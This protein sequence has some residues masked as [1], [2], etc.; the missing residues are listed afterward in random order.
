MK[1]LVDV[2]VFIVIY[3]V[4]EHI[5]ALMEPRTWLSFNKIT[6]RRSFQSVVH[7]L[8]HE[9]E[10][11]VL[12]SRNLLG[13][14]WASTASAPPSRIPYL[15]VRP[16][17][18]S[19][20]NPIISTRGTLSH[21]RQVPAKCDNNLPLP[22]C[23]FPAEVQQ[24]DILPSYCKQ[25]SLSHLHGDLFCIFVKWDIPNF[26]HGM[27]KLFLCSDRLGDVAV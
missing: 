3:K 1:N 20:C 16:S 27:L 7:L 17:L 23:S 24:A 11:P 10:E 8:I 26:C 21:S 12:V 15:Q 5:T 19:I 2:L 13:T 9:Q 25:A 6:S 4:S 14:D 22:A 18:K